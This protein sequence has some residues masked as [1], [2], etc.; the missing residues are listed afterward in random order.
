MGLSSWKD[1]YRYAGAEWPLEQFVEV[2]GEVLDLLGIDERSVPNE[3]LVR[4]YSGEGAMGKPGRDGREAR[5]T[6][7]HLVEFLVTRMLLKDG[8]P[9]SKAAQ[10]IT[11]S[12]LESLEQMLPDVR[13]TPAQLEV[14][15]IKKSMHR[16]VTDDFSA[17]DAR[18]MRLHQDFAPEK[19]PA[20]MFQRPAAPPVRSAS[21]EEL[22]ERSSSASQKMLDLQG[23]MS[24]GRSSLSHLLHSMGFGKHRPEWKETASIDLTPWCTV[25]FDAEQLRRLPH[26]A[27]E[28]LGEALAQSLREHR[29]ATRRDRK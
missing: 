25:T 15:A 4:Y 29:L 20:P 8:W 27:F 2:A 17:L 11:N 24:R 1:K 22:F 26:A 14:R 3:R 16:E 10:F 12:N 9:L 6:W 5:Y 28:P 21:N 23:T 19:S 13:L 7:Q 18:S